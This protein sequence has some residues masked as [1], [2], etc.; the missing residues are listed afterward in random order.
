MSSTLIGFTGDSIVPL[1]TIVL[2]VALGQ[3]QS[4]TL[5]VT[6]MVVGLSTVYNIILGWST[7]NMLRAVISTYHRAIK[8]PARAGVGEVRSDPWE[9]RCCCL[10][11]VTLPKKSRVG[12]S[13]CTET[14]TTPLSSDQPLDLGF[15]VLDLVQLRGCLVGS[16]FGWRN[17]HRP[18]FIL[19]LLDLGHEFLVQSGEVI[20][21]PLGVTH[22]VDKTHGK[23]VVLQAEFISKQLEKISAKGRKKTRQ[24]INI[25]AATRFLAALSTS[26]SESVVYVSLAS[27]RLRTLRQNTWASVPSAHTL[28]RGVSE[29][30][31]AFTGLSRP[32]PGVRLSPEPYRARQE[33]EA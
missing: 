30:H 6:F 28:C 31:L 32:A 13:T 24:Q 33:P 19:Q 5:M 29:A 12:H 18:S 26:T 3:D 11:A 10:I 9:S 23:V 27:G 7:L 17:R 22:P 14:A 4:K 8:F 15:P 16:G 1:G 25:L 21:D 2:P 20:Y